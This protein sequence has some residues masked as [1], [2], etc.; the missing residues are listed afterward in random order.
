MGSHFGRVVFLLGVL[1]AFLLFS[2]DLDRHLCLVQLRGGL[3]TLLAAVTSDGPS[4]E[5]HGQMMQHIVNSE[6]FARE[7]DGV[8]LILSLLVCTDSPFSA[9]FSLL[10]LNGFQYLHL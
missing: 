4:Q 9:G 5:E 10:S 3:E 2:F 1:V 6:L 7:P 8:G